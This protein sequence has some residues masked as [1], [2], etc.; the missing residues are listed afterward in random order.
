[1]LHE[2][3]GDLVQPVVGGDDF[4]ILAQQLLQQRLLV[5]V[6]VGLRDGFGDAVVQVEPGDAELLAAVLVD[7]LH[8]RAVFLGALEVVARDV[9]AE[10]A[11]GQ[12]VVLE[13]A[14]CR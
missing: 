8:G 2:I 13:Q 14:A 6:E 11:L 5:R 4:V 7:Q 9:A 3:G 10:D 1:M 12:V